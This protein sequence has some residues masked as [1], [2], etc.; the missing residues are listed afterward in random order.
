[1][2]DTPGVVYLLHFD[3][4]LGTPGK[5]GARH[6][7]G[8]AHTDRVATRIYSHERGWS[9]VP[10]L[11]AAHRKGIGFVVAREWV[12]A[13][14]ADEKRWKKNG[15]IARKCPLCRGRQDY[16]EVIE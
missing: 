7:M 16:P 14:P 5:G 13:T 10:L 12:G 4:W 2:I 15:G 11:R 6:Y 1:M 3:R 9:Q 8:W